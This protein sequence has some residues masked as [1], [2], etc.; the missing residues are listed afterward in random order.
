MTGKARLFFLAMICF[1]VL[2]GISC[3]KSDSDA[4]KT[5]AK[6]DRVAKKQP[7][8]SDGPLQQ[9]AKQAVDEASI[10]DEWA[11]GRK[12]VESAGYVVKEYRSFPAQETTKKGRVLVYTDKKGKESGGVVFVKKTGFQVA[13]AWHWYFSGMVPDSVINVEVNRDGLWD[14]RVVSTNG[15]AETFTQEESFS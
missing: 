2:T 6:T 3:G 5:K 4:Q 7:A 11:D 15:K 12:V 13:P 9:I 8:K 10:D 1:L 14:I